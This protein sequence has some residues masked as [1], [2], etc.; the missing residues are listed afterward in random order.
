[1]KYEDILKQSPGTVYDLEL[2][3]Y[4]EC[5]YSCCKPQN[6]FG[7]KL[8]ISNPR[9]YNIK[10]IGNS[11]GQLRHL[12]VLRTALLTTC[13]YRNSKKFC[14]SGSP[15]MF[16]YLTQIN[17]S[18]NM[19]LQNITYNSE[20]PLSTNQGNLLSRTNF[21]I[22]WVAN[23]TEELFVNQLT[24]DV[25][26][27]YVNPEVKPVV[28]LNLDLVDSRNILG[29]VEDI[30]QQYIVNEMLVFQGSNSQVIHVL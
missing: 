9:K 29:N 3:S 4:N 19:F 24:N 22:Q 1:M 10:F 30:K 25:K 28:P 23:Y 6:S 21:M 18:G 12:Q 8:K 13:Y 26:N 7:L 5:V 2:N 27:K 11:G 20:V 14:A 15:Y 17:S 16:E